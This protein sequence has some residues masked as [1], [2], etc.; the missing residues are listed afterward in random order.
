MLNLTVVQLFKN[1]ENVV[2]FYIICQSICLYIIR[3][4]NICMSFTSYLIEA[5]WRIYASVKI[6][7]IVSHDG[8]SPGRHQAVICT[9]AWISIIGP[10]ET[11]CSEIVIEIYAFSFKKMHLKIASGNLQSFCLGH[12][13][14]AY[15]GRLSIFSTIPT[16]DT[17]YG[18]SV[19]ILILIHFLSLL[20]QCHTYCRYKLAAL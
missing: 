19:V 20:S 13:M 1:R 17:P 9:N 14:L 8:L 16:M 6:S 10:L 4:D 7:I 5:E 11:N 3:N 2:A 15:H 12:N 18:V